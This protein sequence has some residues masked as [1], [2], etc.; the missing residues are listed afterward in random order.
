MFNKATQIK[1]WRKI[2]LFRFLIVSNSIKCQMLLIDKNFFLLS[3]SLNDKI[4]IQFHSFLYSF[5][6]GCWI[7]NFF[8]ILGT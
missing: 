3:V 6:F 8:V 2:Y 5:L 4:Y 1:I 7:V